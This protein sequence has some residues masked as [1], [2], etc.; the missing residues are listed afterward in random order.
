MSLSSSSGRF[1]NLAV[2]RMSGVLQLAFCGGKNTPKGLHTH[3]PGLPGLP[4][5]PGSCP[6]TFESTLKGLQ[7]RSTDE[8]RPCGTLSGFTDRALATTQG[9]PAC[10][11]EPWAVN[12]KRFQRNSGAP[13]RSVRSHDLRRLSLSPPLPVSPS[14][15]NGATGLQL[16]GAP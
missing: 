5:Y 15:H 13:I 10:A 9:T 8:Q 1:P 3:S 4:G 7:Q 2:S 14:P 12:V 11:G 6:T 16:G